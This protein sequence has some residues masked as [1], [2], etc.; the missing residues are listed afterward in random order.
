MHRGRQEEADSIAAKVG[1]L[2]TKQNCKDLAHLDSKTN[3]FDLWAAVKKVTGKRQITKPL[4]GIN[5]ECLNEHYALV[6]TDNNYIKPCISANSPIMNDTITAM[7]VFNML[8]RLKPTA[9]GPDNLPSWFLRLSAPIIAEPLAQLI[10]LSIHASQVPSQWKSS[11]IK[12]IPKITN[13]I[14][15][16][17][18]RPISITSVLSRIAERMIISQFIYPALLSPPLELTF[19]NQYAFRPTGSTTA[20]LI[21]L[22]HT[23]TVLLESDPYVRVIALDF[24]KAFDTVKHSQL[25]EKANKL[26]IPGNIC[27]W[28]ADFL[29]DRHHCTLFDGELSSPQKINASIVQG[30]A[31][32]PP[33]FAVVASDLITINPSNYLLKFADDTYLIISSS[34]LDT[35]DDE[36]RNIEKWS[37][38]NNLKLNRIKSKEII[39]RRP[40]SNIL[41][42]IPLIRDVERVSDLKCLGV[43]ISSNFS[44]SQH[45]SNTITSCS[46][47]LFALYTLRSKGLSNDLLS[48]IFCAT[49]LSKLLYASQFWWGFTSSQDKERLEAFLRRAFKAG[50]Y[51]KNHTFSELSAVADNKLFRSIQQ[52]QHHLLSHLL[53]SLIM[54]SH[55]TRLNVSH[56]T[57]NI[58]SKRS[59]LSDKNFVTRMALKDS[60]CVQPL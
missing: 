43:T 45:I 46:S 50:F 31:L 51:N 33:A 40:K 29:T 6:S 20:A 11:C 53:P 24:S 48:T 14:S 57:Y 52:N 36:L 18:Y 5:A 49:T 26:D 44:F 56:R 39:F 42:D 13:P 28:I 10:N 30:S 47:N 58:P 4:P 37:L 25:M 55:N 12:P 34:N 19:N 32:G 41:N 2:I 59:T 15:P 60:A 9:T 22:F 8:D 16:S 21:S 54:H 3:S 38:S 27:N 23:I 17:D 7:S 35:T 1:K